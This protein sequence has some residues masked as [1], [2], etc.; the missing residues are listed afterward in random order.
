[1]RFEFNA[2][3]PAQSG[4]GSRRLSRTPDQVRVDEL[5]GR[6]ELDFDEAAFAFALMAMAVIENGAEHPFLLVDVP[7]GPGIAAD[8][9]RAAGAADNRDALAVVRHPASLP[10]SGRRSKDGGSRLVR[11]G[12]GSGAAAC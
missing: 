6:R 3:C 4:F 11:S 1:M 10:K 9:I 7:I 12:R 5:G 8:F 2:R